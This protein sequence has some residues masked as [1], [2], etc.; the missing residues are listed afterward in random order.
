MK[1]RNCWCRVVH[2]GP[3]FENSWT[4]HKWTFAHLV[5]EKHYLRAD[6]SSVSTV[7]KKWDGQLGIHS[8]IPSSSKRDFSLHHSIQKWARIA[9]T[10]LQTGQFM[11]QFPAEARG[12][13]LL[14]NI[15]WIQY[16]R[17]MLALKRGCRYK[18]VVEA[19]HWN[20][21]TVHENSQAKRMK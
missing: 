4:Q 18:T 5:L 14:Q 9:V 1:Y 8:S 16:G 15:Q 3:G 6:N 20:K 19:T 2:E 11:V 7:T 10:K 17:C 21:I 13:S 12:L